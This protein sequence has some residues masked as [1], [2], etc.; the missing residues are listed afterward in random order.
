M[1]KPK[2]QRKL[3]RVIKYQPCKKCRYY[4]GPK[5]CE[6]REIVDMQERGCH[7]WRAKVGR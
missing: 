1:R 2:S 6:C 4:M 3:L 7:D 5:H